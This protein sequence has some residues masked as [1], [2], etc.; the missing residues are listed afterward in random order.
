MG[1]PL[2][3]QVAQVLGESD[4]R[5]Q[6]RKVALAI[7]WR[8]L[9]ESRKEGSKSWV[10]SPGGYNP[11]Q[12]SGYGSTPSGGLASMINHLRVLR[13]HELWVQDLWDLLKQGSA[14]DRKRTRADYARKLDLF[15]TPPDLY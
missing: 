15:L 12:F 8:Q 2:F 10:T 5:D 11:H 1:D 9:Q 14:E 6:A 13:A 7:A 4:Q 3:S